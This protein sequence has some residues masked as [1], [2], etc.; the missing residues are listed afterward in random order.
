[1][2]E[3]VDPK[4]VERE[5]WERLYTYCIQY[6]SVARKPLGLF[7][8]PETRLLALMQ[9]SVMTFITESDE[10]TKILESRK[11][12]V[13]MDVSIVAD[14]PSLIPSMNVVLEGISFVSNSL[15]PEA[16]HV[17]ERQLHD[18]RSADEIANEV[19]ESFI[20]TTKDA[21]TGLALQTFFSRIHLRAPQLTT[22][23]EQ[24]IRSLDLTCNLG[25]EESNPVVSPLDR[26]F[27][28][29]IGRSVLREGLH[30][31]SRKRLEFSRDFL[32]FVSFLIRMR[33][34]T[35]LTSEKIE[36]IRSQFLVNITD[37][38][39]G[40]FIL[41]WFS[42][43]SF[44]DPSLTGNEKEV[45][46][47]HL[48]VL[49]LT[50][51]IRQC[52]L[53]EHSRQSG[54]EHSSLLE[55]FIGDKGLLPA[56]KL[57][58]VKYTDNDNITLE[59]WETVFPDFVESIAQLIWPMSQSL[60]IP[61]FLL[62]F[63]QYNLLRKYIGLMSRFKINVYTW[64]FMLGFVDLIHG[65]SNEAINKFENAVLGVKDEVFLRKFCNI[66]DVEDEMQTDHPLG[67]TEMTDV[68]FNYFNKVIQLFKNQGNSQAVISLSKHS[69]QMIQ[70]RGSQELLH[71]KISRMFTTMFVNYL[72]LENYSQAYDVMIC[73]PDPLPKRDCLRQFIVK[74]YENGRWKDLVSFD[75]SDLTDDFVSIIETKA[76]S[77]D[78]SSRSGCGYYQ[79]LHA[80]FFNVNN[81]RRAAAIMYEFGLRLS[82]E[83]PGI[84]SL[85]QQV[86][87]FLTTIN[88]LKLLPD[89]S[90]S[91]I[92][93]PCLRTSTV[94]P[95]LVSLLPV[96]SDSRKRRADDSV[97]PS[98]QLEIEVL[99]ISDIKSEYELSHA[100]LKLLNKDSKINSIANGVL[101]AAEIVSLLITNNF[102]DCAFKISQM[103]NLSVKPVFEGLVS[104]Y[105]RLVQMPLL[106]REVNESFNEL[107][108]IIAENDRIAQTFLATTESPSPCKMWDIL[109]V[110]LSRHEKTGLTSL[111]RVVAES[112]LLSGVAIPSSLKSSYSVSSSIPC[113]KQSTYSCFKTFLTETRHSRAP[114]VVDDV[115]L[116]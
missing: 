63:K 53:T 80:Y 16:A 59:T 77:S 113:L 39:H 47:A 108:D 90:Q 35:G 86:N 100:R 107:S 8:D 69:L 32:V 97:K 17:F 37:Q 116:H 62:G 28:S 15:T 87:C 9:K 71:D 85:Q 94:S 6:Q 20:L 55:M 74:L 66:D 75:Y 104:K 103:H 38:V 92:L 40:Y 73:N 45:D 76:R 68:M 105:V 91:W 83:V 36:L 95:P 79:L 3:D 115:Q 31:F 42:S 70:G 22:A 44:G 14:E 29:L 19:L 67:L 101:T 5:S 23:I 43:V 88:L 2:N 41:S 1:M 61:E 58:S 50:E 52:R 49:Q 46:E 98:K 99:G 11:P 84:G 18:G 111:H 89:Q 24:L 102:Y 12:H 72:Q 81:L 51:Y 48:N 60:L 4:N 34:K 106:E 93:K 13:S 27:S 64:Q 109:M 112:L 10:T 114:Y 54:S 25:H 78:L 57:L 82:R 26:L 96:S 56:K 30:K 33:D 110:Y 7:L 65:K 21:S